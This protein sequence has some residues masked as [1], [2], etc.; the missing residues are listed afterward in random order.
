MISPRGLLLLGVA[1]LACGWAAWRAGERTYVPPAVEDAVP[2][3]VTLTGEVP[4][5]YEARELE[6]EG[7]CCTGCSAKLH[8][9]LLALSEVREAAVDPVLGTAW[10]VVPL[11]FEAMRLEEALTFDKYTAAAVSPGS[12]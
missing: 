11:G 5:G 7:M 9:A 8:G 10:A 1:G 3:P 2:T 4:S 6:V 12:P